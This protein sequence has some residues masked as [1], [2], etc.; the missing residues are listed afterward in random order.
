MPTDKKKKKICHEKWVGI[1]LPGKIKISF[2]APVTY[3][4]DNLEMF[5][6]KNYIILHTGQ[7]SEYYHREA[8]ILSGPPE[9]KS[10]KFP[11][12]VH[13]G[14]SLLAQIDIN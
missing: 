1:F 14:C 9:L 12:H 10:Y 2:G 4:E 5:P 11:I 7:Y 6:W 8:A 13:A 3:E